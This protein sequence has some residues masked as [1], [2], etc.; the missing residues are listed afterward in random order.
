MGSR[1]VESSTSRPI[2]RTDK[3]RI[4]VGV[5][6]PAS[7]LV[8][9]LYRN[10]PVPN[11]GNAMFAHKDIATGTIASLKFTGRWDAERVCPETATVVKVNRKGEEIWF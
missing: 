7:R 2:E 9:F 3:K 8:V 1:M 6:T 5:D 11:K 4:E 10:N